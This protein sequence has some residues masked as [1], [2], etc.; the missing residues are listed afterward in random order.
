MKIFCYALLGLLLLGGISRPLAARELRL[1][2]WN[3]E[4]LVSPASARAAR[5]RCLRGQAAQLPCDVA[6]DAARSS[7]DFAVLARYARQLNADVVAFQ[8]VEDASTAAKVFSGYVFCLT[9]RNEAQNVGFAIRVGLPHRCAPDYLPLSL[10]DSLRRGAVAVLFP[11]TADEIHLLGV[12]LKSGCARDALPSRSRACLAL[13]RQ[14][15]LLGDWIRAERAAGHRF[16]VLGDFNRDL[17]RDL[18]AA[19]PEVEGLIDAAQG[20]TF[21]N[22]YP[23]QTFTRYIDHILLG[24]DLARKQVHGSFHRL[25]YLPRD[26]R[27]YRLSDHCPISILLRTVA[28]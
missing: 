23:G 3:L 6:L 27:R 25:H 1:A 11:G 8:E 18:T 21:S 14:L 13:G 22:C 4:W 12:H 24:G 5:S 10:G 15:P 19:L 20:T 26:A 17:D 9:G 28:R 2:S 16:A 7:A